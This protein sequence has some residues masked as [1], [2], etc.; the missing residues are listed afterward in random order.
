MILR[1]VLAYEVALLCT[2]NY[3]NAW[4]YLIFNA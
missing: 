1:S 4:A 2:Y 3:T